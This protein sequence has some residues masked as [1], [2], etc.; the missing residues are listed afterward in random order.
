MDD[1][2]ERLPEEFN[3]AEIMQKDPNRGPYVL[4]CFQECER[5]NALIC[6]IRMSLQQFHLGLKVS[7]QVGQAGVSPHWR[8]F[9]VAFLS[10]QGRADLISGHGSTAVGPE[11]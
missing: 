3:V 9:M 8:V 1:I 4:V 7:V 6:E 5:M 2:L 11:L 10:V